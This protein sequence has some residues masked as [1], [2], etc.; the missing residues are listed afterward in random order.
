MP[1]TLV[2]ALKKVHAKKK[3]S[4]RGGGYLFQRKEGGMYHMQFYKPNPDTGHADKVVECTWTANHAEAQKKLNERL[5]QVARGEL[6]ET[7]KRKTVADLYTA[8]HTHVKNNNPKPRAASEVAWHW[9]GHLKPAFGHLFAAALNTQHIEKYKEQRRAEGAAA[10]TVNHELTTLRRMYRHGMNKCTPKLVHTMPAIHL[11]P[12]AACNVRRGFIDLESYE[13]MAP[14]AEELYLRALLEVAFS[15]GWRKGELL[16]MRVR[17][18]DF[19]G[20]ELRL[21]TSK[22][23]EPRTVPMTPTVYQLLKALCDGKEPN[24]PVFTREDGSPV[25]DFRFP[26][27]DLCIRAAVPGPDGT[28]S[29]YICPKCAAEIP[30]GQKFCNA[31]TKDGY[32]C[33]G[34]RKYAGLV[35]HNTRNSFAVNARRSGVHKHTAMDLAGWKTDSMFR[36]YD[37]IE[38]AD[39]LDAL[40][41]MAAY[42][43][44]RKPTTQPTDE[45]Q[46][47][48]A[49][50]PAVEVVQ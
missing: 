8:L 23:G 26:W 42:A 33:G 44:N 12:K 28:P 41:K 1:E 34:L 24:D 9:E 15:Y 25:K 39:Q 11:F 17:Q 29:R 13:R 49:A 27:Q 30:L 50:S 40:A 45:Q 20:R 4:R 2:V 7:G 19:V 10:N 16:T 35:F 48:L 37:H 3:R 5:A 47:L 43:A 31:E 18:A 46:A 6:F 38:A 36:Q 32:K 22:N 14:L 21:F